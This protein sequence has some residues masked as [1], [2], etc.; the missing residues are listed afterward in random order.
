M[1]FQL[2][3]EQRML[4]EGAERFLRESYPF[5]RRRTTLAAA[6]RCNDS[7]W[8][9]F[10]ELGWLALLLPEDVGGFGRGTIREARRSPRQW[11]VGSSPS[12]SLT[13]AVLCARLIDSW[14]QRSVAQ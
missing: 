14:R 10:A 2:T 9:S 1:E 3:D 12:R 5:E 8:Q 13:S 6:T 11:G 7:M 4:Q